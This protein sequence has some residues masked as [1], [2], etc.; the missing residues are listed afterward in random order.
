MYWNNQCLIDTYTL[1]R[2]GF[3]SVRRK[4]RVTTYL[5]KRKMLNK[6]MCGDEKGEPHM[7]LFICLFLCY[8]MMLQ[9]DSVGPCFLF[10]RSLQFDPWRL[11]WDPTKIMQL[12]VVI[13][14]RYVDL[15]DVY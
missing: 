10:F 7:L 8:H 1:P 2:V 5:R 4:R 3:I 14:L 13:S 12:Y 9:P 15:C 6:D 11:E